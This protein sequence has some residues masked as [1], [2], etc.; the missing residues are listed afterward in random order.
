MKKS[1]DSPE[2]ETISEIWR[3]IDYIRGAEGL[4]QY[5]ALAV[6]LLFLRFLKFECDANTIALPLVK[7]DIMG[8]VDALKN[9]LSGQLVLGFSKEQID[10]ILDN[11]DHSMA[12]L[13]QDE[14]V[15][16]ELS[17]FFYSKQALPS[18]DVAKKAWSVL[19]QEFTQNEA[20]S[21]TQFHTPRDINLLLKGLGVRVK[22][23]SICDPFAGC[24]ETAF[25]FASILSNA[26]IVT[27]EVH[28]DAYYHLLIAQCFAS[29]S[30]DC[31]HADTL[32][33]PLFRSNT[34][35]LV[36]SCPPFGLRVPKAK[37]NSVI[38]NTG[39]QGHSR[40][41]LCRGLPEPNPEWLL[42]L[43]M[44]GAV[45]TNGKLISLCTAGALKREGSETAVRKKVVENGLV[46][47]VIL[48]P[49]SMLYAS[50]VQTAV[51]VMNNH[52]ENKRKPVRF[53]DAS[54][55]YEPHPGK[56]TFSS[57]HIAEIV[58]AADED[59]RYSKRVDYDVLAKNNF[60]L[61]PSIYIPK[62]LKINRV[63]LSNFRSYTDLSIDIHENLTVLVGENGSG[64]TT[65][66]DAIA[67]SF[68]PFFSSFFGSPG[69]TIKKSDIQVTSTGLVDYAQVAIDSMSS[70][71]WDISLKENPDTLVPE[72]G[73]A[74]L[75][76]YAKTFQNPD[77]PYPMLVHFGVDR[78]RKST[79]DVSIVVF[80]EISRRAGYEGAMDARVSYQS[81]QRWFAK[82]EVDELAMRDKKQDHGLVHPAKHMLEKAIKTMI[83]NACSVQYDKKL[84][85]IRI[86]WKDSS[87]QDVLLSLY[88]LSDGYQGMMALTMDLI[89]RAFYL[90]PNAEDPLSVEGIV[91]IDEIEL[92]LHPRWQQNI[93]KDL[94][95]L[96]PNVQ[97]IVTTHSPQV[98]T[99][100]KGDNIRAISAG[101]NEAEYVSSPYG[102]ESGRVLEEVLGVEQR[103]KTDV[104]SKLK[105]YF[106]LIEAGSGE[107]EDALALRLDIEKL[108][109]G[110]EPMLVKADLAIKRVKWLKS[111]KES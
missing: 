98:L 80:E 81:I 11:I 47:T 102:G 65:I 40:V 106:D 22:P 91:L 27:Q 87:D 37:L 111:K 45:N 95:D 55:L 60:D 70:L 104:L 75:V 78:I 25:Q 93:L 53:V 26:N 58:R 9:T 10:V 23:S 89:R 107:S 103:P 67:C 5:K 84:R 62:T 86:Q 2:Q 42:L 15:R 66:L 73:S 20:K 43:C 3:L 1:S 61:N 97:F 50:P 64:K 32:T 83:P 77:Q 96:F 59:G 82:I 38:D 57:E 88:Q 44:L 31:H 7:D 8:F 19:L 100:V 51:L 29:I 49:E 41:D 108:T 92:H 69:K 46:D 68:S 74:A 33:E 94:T 13:V 71:S 101:G 14:T 110:N 12:S 63:H 90:N 4:D 109:D 56:N 76:D 30:G 18:Q 105:E 99:T 48:L 17:R 35:D 21:Q 39:N 79:G 52:G 16:S 72:R 54:L 24:G 85:D 28:A 6:S 36:V 34:Y